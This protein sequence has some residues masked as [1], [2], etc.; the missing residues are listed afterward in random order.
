MEPDRT[1]LPMGFRSYCKARGLPIPLPERIPADALQTPAARAVLLDLELWNEDLVNAWETYLLCGGFPRAVSDFHDRGSVSGEF[2]DALRDVVRSEVVGQQTTLSEPQLLAVLQAI[3]EGLT[4]SVS[5]RK[6]AED[7]GAGRNAVGNRLD[8]F[9]TAYLTWRLYQEHR[10]MPKLRGQNKTYF[11]DPMLARLPSLMSPL[12]PEPG[13]DKLTE[14]QL[15]LALL[16]AAEDD[17]K[18]S[19]N[20]ADRI[21][22]RRT[23]TGNEIDF[24][25]GSFAIVPLESKYSDGPWRR[26]AL[27]LRS[28]RHGGLMCTRSV[29][30]LG[31]EEIWAVPAAF[32]AALIDT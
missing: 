18:G 4:S 27:T 32:V 29:L 15:G 26:D 22:F 16:R 11:T 5:L 30:D 13:M 19:T 1:L 14:Q 6:V 31:D 28:N 8:D 20:W 21:L 7:V 3:S 2:V 9:C 24:V 12:L 23:P 25:S 10:Q 17:R